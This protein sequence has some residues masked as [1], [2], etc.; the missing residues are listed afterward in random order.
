MAR[1]TARWY[2]GSRRNCC[3][4]EGEDH[5]Q[6]WPVLCLI[7]IVSRVKATKEGLVGESL[8][9]IKR[10]HIESVSLLHQFP[11]FDFPAAS[12]PTDGVSL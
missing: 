6:L 11:H 10:G 8:Y 9:A 4:K 2:G 1:Q 12:L 3:G 7:A 5:I